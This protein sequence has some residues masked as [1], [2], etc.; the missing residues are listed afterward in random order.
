MNPPSCGGLRRW[1]LSCAA[2]GCC[3]GAFGQTPPPPALAGGTAA[4]TASTNFPPSPLFQPKTE[5]FRKIL[6]MTPAEQEAW[7]TNRPAAVRS[8]LAGKIREYEAMTPD[9]RESVLR[10]TELHEYLAYFVKVAPAAR[11]SQLAQVPK[12]YRATINMKLREFDVLPP[13]LQKEVLAGRSTA[14]YFLNPAP[15]WAGA[16]HPAHPTAPMPPPLP[17]PRE[18]LQYLNRLPPD[19]RRKMYTSFEHFFD[20]NNDDRQKILATLP[21][22]ERARVEKTLHDLESLPPEQRDRGLKS[23]SMLAKMTDEQRAAFFQNAAV[24]EKLPPVEQQTW[25]K[26]VTHLPPLPPLPDPYAAAVPA[27]S[28]SPGGFS[29]LTN[30]AN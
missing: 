9:S 8:Q 6:A 12:E 27:I 14:N 10:A 2:L 24:W 15:L 21:A 28:S 22:D 26:V 29:V 16:A 19:E 25:R 13:D 30:P 4:T 5:L 23:I 3:L 1:L 7:L 11:A 20:L 18:A 17:Q